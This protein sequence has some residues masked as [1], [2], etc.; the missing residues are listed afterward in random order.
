MASINNPRNA[1]GMAE[2]MVNDDDEDVDFDL[3]E[4]N[5][6]GLLNKQEEEKPNIAHTYIQ[7]MKDISNAVTQLDEPVRLS[8]NKYSSA[9]NHPAIPNVYK[10]PIRT[11]Q[12]EHMDYTGIGKLEHA[13]L[14]E[15]KQLKVMTNEERKQEQIDGVFKEI[16]TDD[17][18]FSFTKEE[19]EDDMAFKLEQI[20]MLK[21]SLSN[22]G[23][24]ISRV[25]DVSPS[26]E[27]SE[28]NAVH[29]ILLL[30]NDRQRYADVFEEI[31]LSGA[32]G[33]ETLFD[34]QK[35]YFNRKPDLTGWSEQ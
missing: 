12:K 14:I 6:M 26:S 11:P 28:I 30:K 32:Y 1:M 8:E 13:P 24:D 33:L 3:V 5:V 9:S 2:L 19:Q 10:A 20:D 23:V 7:E 34:G 16:E 31:I 21:T 35:E 18:S 29:K 25:P 27:S 22:D 15:D 4:K 17:N